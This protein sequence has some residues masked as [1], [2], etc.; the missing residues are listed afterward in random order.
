MKSGAK[1]VQ[2][3]FGLSSWRD[4]MSSF[5]SQGMTFYR[6]MGFLKKKKKGKRMSQSQKQ[7]M[8]Q[9]S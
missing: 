6:S 3:L 9:L 7:D 8:G 1:C 4:L 5:E 2:T